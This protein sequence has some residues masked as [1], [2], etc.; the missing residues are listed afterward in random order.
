[1]T[2]M[3]IV[4]EDR[5][6]EALARRV[7]AESPLTCSIVASY[8]DMS[9]RNAV[10]GNSY[11]EQNIHGFNSAAAHSPFL[12]LLDLDRR[13]CT[14]RYR[15]ELLPYGPA[16]YMVLRIAV[17]EA[18]SWVLADRDSFATF[19]SVSRDHVPRVPDDLPDAKDALFKTI[20]R[21]R[22]RRMQDAIL[23]SGPTTSHG[24]DYNGTLIRYLHEAWRIDQAESASPSLRRARS[25][26]ARLRFP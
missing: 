14:V 10:A 8:R 24:P 16:R 12:V 9:R 25:A 4:T 26:V 20:R 3:S 5:L 2:P 21:S 22:S 11:I 1:M 23:P 13:V 18:E 15:D 6:S 19:F 7:L 17:T